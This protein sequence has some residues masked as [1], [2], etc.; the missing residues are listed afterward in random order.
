MTQ[1]SFASS[2]AEVQP[3]TIIFGPIHGFIPGVFPVRAGQLLLKAASWK[4]RRISHVL[5]AVGHGEAVQAM[6]HGAELI[7]LTKEH[8]TPEYVYV[9]PEYVP[10]GRR[11]SIHEGRDV[12]EEARKLIGTP[13]SFL[14]YAALAAHQL[15]NRGYVPLKERTKLEQY[16]ASTGHM[17]CSQLAD[18]AL[19]RAGF[20][21]F[22]DGR[23]PQDVMPA[24]LYTALLPL[25]QSIIVP[26]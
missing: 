12:A 10:A 1:D 6:P 24:A 16:V 9:L 23:L 5:V 25:A 22:R 2:P 14:D 17:I 18:E 4:T 13:Y 26:S 19:S 11:D 8:W 21:V 7:K 3:G 15:H 20:H